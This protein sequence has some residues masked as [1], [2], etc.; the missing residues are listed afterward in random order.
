MGC[1]QST[2]KEKVIHAK[3]AVDTKKNQVGN[4]DSKSDKKGQKSEFSTPAKSQHVKELIQTEP[5]GNN[6]DT[7]PGNLTPDA[8]QGLFKSLPQTGS[9]TALETQPDIKTEKEKE[10]DAKAD[11]N[12]LRRSM[13]I[14]INEEEHPLWTEVDAIWEDAKAK[15]SQCLTAEQAK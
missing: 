5:N 9:A 14:T 4:E 7:G 15:H 12:L 2:D 6:F 1:T 10:E 11:K 13:T 3:K 8:K